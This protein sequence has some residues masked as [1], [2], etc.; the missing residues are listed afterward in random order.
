MVIHIPNQKAYR[1]ASLLA[2]EIVP[3]FGVPKC[4]LSDRGTSSAEGYL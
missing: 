1:I 3:V 4:L 2:E